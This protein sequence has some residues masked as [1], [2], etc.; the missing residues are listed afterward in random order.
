MGTNFI[1]RIMFL[2]LTGLFYACGGGEWR[3]PAELIRS[4]G[5]AGEYRAQITPSFM[6]TTAVATGE[7]TIHVTDN[8]DGSIRLFFNGF[9]EPE[10][11]FEMTV[12]INM[13]VSPGSGN[14]LLLK[15]EGGVFRA[16]PPESGT[17]DPADFPEG[18]VL[19]EGAENGLYSD[20]ATIEGIY[21]EIEKDGR[22]AFRFDLALTPGVPLPIEVLIYTHEKLNAG[23]P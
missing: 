16:D 17:V 9:R 2:P 14:S 5:L 21:G 8:G 10:M 20:Q 12:D 1:F 3:T 13:A 4:Y 7:Y 18:I 22:T 15:G 6:G 23:N 11:P 19:P